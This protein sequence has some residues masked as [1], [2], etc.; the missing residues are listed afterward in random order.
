M[1]IHMYM[2]EEFFLYSVSEDLSLN[3][4]SNI[5]LILDFQNANIL[6]ICSLRNRMI[7]SRFYYL[8]VEDFW[9]LGG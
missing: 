8:Y 7:Q 6:A 2:Y 3:Q 9:L 5:K 4:I 1:Y